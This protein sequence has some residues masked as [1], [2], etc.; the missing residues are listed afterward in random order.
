MTAMAAVVISTV[1][2]TMVAANEVMTMV[3]VVRVTV[4][5]TPLLY[6]LEAQVSSSYY[7][8]STHQYWLSMRCFY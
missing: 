8:V 3:T 6:T 7:F 5:A 4:S 2:M 1:E